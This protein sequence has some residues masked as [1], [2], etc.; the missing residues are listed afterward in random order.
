[1]NEGYM[2]RRRLVGQTE[3]GEPTTRRHSMTR[4]AFL[5]CSTAA[6]M[7]AA[8]SANEPEGIIDCNVTIGQWPFRYLAGQE[9]SGLPAFCQRL[10]S[11]GVTQGWAASSEGIFYPDI[12]RANELLHE[13]FVEYSA[14]LLIPVG[15]INPSLPAW[16]DDLGRCKDKHEMKIIRLHPNFHGYKLDDPVFTELLSAATE[17]KLLV[18]ITAQME[19]ERTQHPLMRVPPVDLKPLGDVIKRVPGARVMVLNANASMIATALRGVDV[20]VDIAMLEGV[21]GIE[22]IL[23]TWPLERLVFGSHAPLFYWEAAKLKLQESELSTG[24][25]AAITH[26]NAAALIGVGTSH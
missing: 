7:L 12:A 16:R 4:R 14:R 2:E 6:T 26:G 13:R 21:G 17:A 9:T 25:L 23:A 1:M 15:S 19:D 11:K 22:N 20:S 18:Q 24:Q 8:A 3:A 10:K 5:G